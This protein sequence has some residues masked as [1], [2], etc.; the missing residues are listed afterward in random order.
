[1]AENA[2]GLLAGTVRVVPYNPEWAELFAAERQ[3]LDHVLAA[4]GISLVIEH[5][6]STAVRGLAA[7][8]VLDILAG[9]TSGE[10]RQ[11][12]INALQ[13]AGYS[14]RGEQG[15]PERDFFRRGEPR[16]YHVHLARIGS[17]F[18]REHRAFRDY[19]R[20]HDA[21]AAAYGLLKHTLAER[22]PDDRAAYIEGKT[23][24]V[25]GVLAR[26]LGTRDGAP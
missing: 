17:R 7:K 4:H 11:P 21:V 12:A 10:Q 25:D 19:L 23:A 22:H 26:A 1:V 14:Y 15:I 9:W 18:W 3:R 13:G 8:P 16:Q 2:L 20:T 5:T 24:F 6:G